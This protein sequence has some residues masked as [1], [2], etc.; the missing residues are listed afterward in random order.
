MAYR[1]EAYIYTNTQIHRGCLWGA[2][3]GGFE[4]DFKKGCGGVYLCIYNN[5]Y[6]YINNLD[7]NYIYTPCVSVCIFK[8]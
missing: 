1:F 8:K 2:F 3:E 5:I 4:C 6:I 7:P